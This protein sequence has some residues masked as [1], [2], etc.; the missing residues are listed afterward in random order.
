MHRRVF[1]AHLHVIDPRFPLVENQGFVPEPFTVDDY[2]ARVAS[3]GVVGGAVVSGSFQ[4][5]DQSYLRAALEALGP[6]FVGVTQLPSS[7]TDDE[8][9]GLD[10]IG[11][12]AIRFNLVRGGEANRT[13]L[14]RLARRVY[15][16][17]GWHVELYVPAADLAGFVPLLTSLP[18]VVIDHLGL[19]QEAHGALR[20]LVA[21][22][23]KVKA[24]GF[25]R[26]DFDPIPIICELSAIDPGALLFGTDLPSTRAPRPFRDDDL[27]RLGAVL[28]NV[29]TDRILFRNAAS[30]YRA[31]EH[32]RNG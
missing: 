15:D 6:S 30:F 32:P 11:V 17:A 19:G 27:H 3:L 9:L 4:A 21:K 5:F 1:D 24:S 22:G 16:V 2:R 28:G 14:E 8:I 29:L 25:A 13:E 10:R 18:R 7:V 31:P 26:L 20:E 12:R 23:T